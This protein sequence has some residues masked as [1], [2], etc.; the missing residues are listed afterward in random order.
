MLLVHLYFSPSSTRLQ[1]ITCLKSCSFCT[2]NAFPKLR[3]SCQIE[4][5]LHH[6]Q[7]PKA[8]TA[9]NA[10]MCADPVSVFL[11]LYGAHHKPRVY[12]S[13][14]G[15]DLA[16]QV[17]CCSS[18]VT[19]FFMNSEK[20]CPCHWQYF[21]LLRPTVSIKYA[22]NCWATL[23]RNTWTELKYNGSCCP[24]PRSLQLR[25]CLPST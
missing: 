11:N 1:L 15:L 19:L 7:T 23:V 10:F 21:Y 25:H 12:S 3:S 9:G 18:F 5:R 20:L 22:Q 6:W 13:D 2:R 16:L 4:H 24:G 17:A 8:S 14:P